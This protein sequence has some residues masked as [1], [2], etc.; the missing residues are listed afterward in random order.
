MTTVRRRPSQY[1]TS[2]PLEEL[3]VVQADGTE[4]RLACKRLSWSA[5]ENE[6]RL[7]KPRFLH[8]PDREPA[9][10]AHV[11]PQAPPGPPRYHGSFTD[12]EGGGPRL[13]VEWVE[14]RE[15][16]QVGEREHWEAAASWLGRMHVALAGDLDRHAG[17]GRLL[18]YDANHYRVWLERAGE[19][20]RAPGQPR[21]RAVAVERIAQRYE[22]AIEELLALPRTVI[23]GEL[24]A[25]NVLVAGETHSPRIAPVDWELA[26]AAPGVVDLA[27]LTSGSGWSD[28]DRS[29]I[30]AAYRSTIP[31]GAPSARDLDLARLHL[32]VQWLGWAPP[33]WEPPANQRQDWQGEALALVE[34]LGL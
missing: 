11:L 32:A 26:A 28:R 12:P 8:D 16:Y 23:H 17:R 14:G 24:Y 4:L 21:S 3:S 34:E 7:A 1:Q 2:F 29:A 10:Y 27:A 31:S 6:A 25:S 22:E 13:L 5:L 19:F 30:V 15:L 20:A 18:E 9:V 33:S